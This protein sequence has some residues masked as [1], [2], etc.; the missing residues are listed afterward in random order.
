M[1][2]AD[3]TVAR[4]AT[5]GMVL[6]L[7]C[8]QLVA[9]VA[10]RPLSITHAHTGHKLSSS[11]RAGYPLA[12]LDAG[13]TVSSAATTLTSR[14]REKIEDAE[15]ELLVEVVHSKKFLFR[16]DG[17]REDFAKAGPARR[18]ALLKG[19]VDNEQA[20]WRALADAE[21]AGLPQEYLEDGIRV[22]NE[23]AIARA[24]LAHDY[25]RLRKE[26]G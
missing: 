19:C 21:V 14:L 2:A 7:A 3:G 16:G 24:Q 11:P 15:D 9:F 12:A 18:R 17:L 4:S 23:L 5:V 26:E 6:L 10:V 8:V 22:A 20:L 1:C 25:E 13:E